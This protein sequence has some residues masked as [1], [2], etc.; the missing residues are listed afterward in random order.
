TRVGARATSPRARA[1]RMLRPSRRRA[2]GIGSARSRPQDSAIRG[3]CAATLA[4]MPQVDRFWRRLFLV[5]IPICVATSAYWA[6]A[7]ADFVTRTFGVA[8]VDGAHLALVRQ[9]AGVVFSLLAWTYGRW[10]LSGSVELRPF[11][12]LQEGLALGDVFLVVA[13]IVGGQGG[14]MRADAA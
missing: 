2:G 14:G 7:P 11:R 8:A 1:G 10:L 4:R 5:E 3:R 6:L 9:L 13:A 12:F